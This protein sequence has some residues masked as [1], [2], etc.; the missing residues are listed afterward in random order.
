[1]ETA[2]DNLKSYHHHSYIVSENTVSSL[3]VIVA[4]DRGIVVKILNLK[5]LIKRT[6]QL[7]LGA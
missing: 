6:Y 5:A 1:M 7:H 3:L 2:I 4:S